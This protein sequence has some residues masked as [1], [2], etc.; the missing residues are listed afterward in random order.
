MSGSL[1]SGT[2]P[3]RLDALN[4]VTNTLVVRA[5]Q[6]LMVEFANDASF[7]GTLVIERR[8]PRGAGVWAVTTIGG[9]PASFSNVTVVEQFLPAIDGVE[10][11]LRVSAYTSGSGVGA[12]SQ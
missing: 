10:W 3:T 2:G 4:A 8:D 7:V 1:R 12:L 11:R 9:Q 5:N 6:P